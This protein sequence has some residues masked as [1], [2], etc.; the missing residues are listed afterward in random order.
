MRKGTRMRML[1]RQMEWD[2]SRVYYERRL[3]EG[4]AANS[5]KIMVLFCEWSQ[6]SYNRYNFEF[7]VS[8]WRAVNWLEFLSIQWMPKRNGSKWT[9]K[10]SRNTDLPF[11]TM[12]YGAKRAIS[13]RFVDHQTQFG[14]QEKAEAQH[15]QLTTWRL[16]INDAGRLNLTLSLIMQN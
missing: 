2:S 6:F 11:N 3:M 16:D 14:E 12:V 10:K 9:K 7:I 13:I 1:W 15:T 4:V 5:F 8:V